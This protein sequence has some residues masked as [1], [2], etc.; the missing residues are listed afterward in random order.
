MTDYI[1]NFKPNFEKVIHHFK[2]EM[3]GL[4][5]GRAT[6]SILEN[7]KVDAYETVTPLIQLA[8]IQSPEPK[9][10][11]I[12]PWD[13]TL[14]KVIAKAIESANLGVS[15]SVDEQCV[16]VNFPSLTE[17]NRLEIVKQL[18]KKT[19]EAR[20]SVRNQREKIK[21]VVIR[22][23]K[24]KLISEDEKYKRIDELDKLVKDY[25]EEIKNLAEAKEKEIMTV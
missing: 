24:D 17:E 10:L 7:I 5:I 18:H 3:A 12:Q 21:E 14:L 22:E 19:E 13:K 20:V 15:T 2:D 11:T 16:R 1:Q 23:E 6:P 4:R 9:I 25:N 8:G